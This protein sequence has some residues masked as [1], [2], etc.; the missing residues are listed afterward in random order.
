MDLAALLVVEVSFHRDPVH[1]LLD[2]ISTKRLAD[3][4]YIFTQCTCLRDILE[5]AYADVA[6]T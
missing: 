3:I 2:I 6:T 1:D 5:T 4:M